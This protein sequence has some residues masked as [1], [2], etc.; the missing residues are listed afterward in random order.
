MSLPRELRADLERWAD[1]SGC[2]LLVVFGSAAAG[3][4]RE[5]SDLDLAVSFDPL[6]DAEGRLR[7]VGRLEDGCGGRSVDVIFLRPE[8]D[9]VLRFEIFRDGEPVFEREPGL[10]VRERVRAVMLHQDALPFRRA[11]AERMSAG[12]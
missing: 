10:F 11:L 3:R 8:T 4:A 2:R 7:L 1:A 12:G 5:G 9:P 6:P